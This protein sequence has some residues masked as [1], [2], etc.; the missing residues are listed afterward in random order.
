M[1]AALG[2]QV[3]TQYVNPNAPPAKKPTKRKP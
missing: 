3:Q 1:L 2:G